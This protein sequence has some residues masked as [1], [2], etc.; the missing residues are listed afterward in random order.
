[1]SKKA[2]HTVSP[3]TRKSNYSC[4]MKP[5]ISIAKTVENKL[6]YSYN[7]LFLIFEIK[8]VLNV[9]VYLNIMHV[10]VYECTRIVPQI[11]FYLNHAAALG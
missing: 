10:Y 5:I 6:I 4:Q 9:H 3:Y 2:A 8:A 11:L 1:M 7:M